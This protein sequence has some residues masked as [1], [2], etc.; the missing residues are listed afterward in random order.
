ME[1]NA[2]SQVILGMLGLGPMCGYEIKQLVDSSTRF[3]WA[4]S[5]G[6]IY[7]E[8]RRLTEGGLISGEAEPHGNRKRTVFSLTPAGREALERWLAEP[9]VVQEMRDESL[10][11]V[12]FSDAGGPGATRAALEAKRD[13]HRELAARLRAVDRSEAAEQRGSTDTALRYGIA[14]NDFIA[15]WCER[16]A[17]AEAA[18]PARNGS[19]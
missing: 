4:A 1:L 8:L 3:F 12:F 10:L 18:A 15:E 13:H 19:G 2:T 7:P 14:L 6:Q 11:K 9:P 17:R 5:Y 16:E